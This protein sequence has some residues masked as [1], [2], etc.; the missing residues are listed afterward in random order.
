MYRQVFTT[1]H[2]WHQMQHAGGG[3]WSTT[4]RPG[5]IASA[6]FAP[7]SVTAVCAQITV[8]VRK[9]WGGPTEL[10]LVA[11]PLPSRTP[12]CA[13]TWTP[14]AS[15]PAISRNAKLCV[16]GADA[17][18]Q[19]LVPSSA[20]IVLVVSGSSSTTCCLVADESPSA[21][22]LARRRSV[23]SQNHLEKTGRQAPD[24]QDIY[25]ACD[26]Y[27]ITAVRG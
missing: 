24:N 10:G 25:S 11:L 2:E 9:R 23:V 16:A 21:K 19:P 12:P 22:V 13:T 6:T 27:G 5:D 15:D 26:T 20:G 7:F 1:A 8:N 14:G 17:A 3:S 18:P 4:N